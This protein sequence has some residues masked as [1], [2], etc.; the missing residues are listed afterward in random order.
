[1]NK[2]YVMEKLAYFAITP[3]K[4]KN[5]KELESLDGFVKET[6]NRLISTTAGSAAG[7]ASGF[8]LGIALGK[9]IAAY[10]AARGKRIPPSELVTRGAMA[11]AA[12]GAFI[13]NLAA[14]RE[15]ERQAGVKNSTSL[16]LFKRGV[17]GFIGSKIIP[18]ANLG[19]FLGD[20][21]VSR[22]IN[23]YKEI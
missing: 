10:T 5:K 1:M 16:D 3:F 2:D 20:Y 21:I 13:G 12:A 14:L 23:K 22:K 8:G 11:G 9:V 6:G 15:T 18:T 17:G 19:N 4:V 7:L